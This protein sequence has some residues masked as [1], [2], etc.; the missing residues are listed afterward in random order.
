MEHLNFIL[1]PFSRTGICNTILPSRSGPARGTFLWNPGGQGCLP[2]VGCMPA[3][4]Q[5][6][7]FSF[8]S[9]FSLL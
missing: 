4:V 9:Q 1:G 6:G 7:F 2:V 8:V 3:S 5:F